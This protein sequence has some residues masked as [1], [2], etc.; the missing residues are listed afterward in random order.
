MKIARLANLRMKKSIR[1]HRI[2]P[3]SPAQ[4]LD[5]A[6]RI[7]KAVAYLRANRERYAAAAAWARVHLKEPENGILAGPMPKNRHRRDG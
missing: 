3:R 7:A 1:E 5:L 2:R 4:E 6:R